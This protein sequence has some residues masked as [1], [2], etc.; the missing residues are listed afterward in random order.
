MQNRPY[1]QVRVPTNL[2]GAVTRQ[3]VIGVPV[4]LSSLNKGDVPIL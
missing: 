1:C 3:S 4:S 2:G